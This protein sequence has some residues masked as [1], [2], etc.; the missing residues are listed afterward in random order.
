MPPEQVK[1]LQE[2]AAQLQRTNDPK[3]AKALISAI[4]AAVEEDL[5][6][7]EQGRR[8]RAQAAGQTEVV[9]T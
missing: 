7:A 4:Q 2:K 1:E 8:E 3:V 9:R 6:A 5:R